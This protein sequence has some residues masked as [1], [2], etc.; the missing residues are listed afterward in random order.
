MF[1]N[2]SL[3]ETSAVQL[4]REKSIPNS[5]PRNSEEF[6]L[7]RVG[8]EMY[9]AFYLGYTLKQWE[10]HPQELDAS[11]CGR[12][13]IRFNRD[14]RYVDHKYQVTPKAGFSEM[15]RKMIDHPGISIQLKTD[16]RQIKETIHPRVATIYCGPI[17]E[18]F[19]FKFGKLP[20]RSLRFEFKE[21]LQPYVQPCVQINYSADHDYTRTVEIKHVTGQKS[22][23]TV[24]S[25]E[26]PT[27]DGDPYYPIPAPESRDLFLKY[28]GLVAKETATHGVYFAGRLANYRYIN[29]DEVM[30]QALSLFDEIAKQKLGEI[31]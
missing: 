16:Y 14:E 11:V 25:Y 24:I 27:A 3:D 15:F 4:L 2:R 10:R 12:I 13:P 30:D 19:D 7:S 8:K 9:E 29:M 21:E 31:K 28:Q 23:N 1:F 6:V 22:D 26:Y 17:D 18:Y 5:S 20:W